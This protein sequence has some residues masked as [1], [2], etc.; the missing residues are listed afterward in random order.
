MRFAL[1][2]YTV[3]QQL[4]GD[5][6]G[7]LQRI[8][9]FGFRAVE[10]YPFPA[11]IPNALAAD[12]LRDIGL[13][14]VAIHADL[15][16][17]AG[18]GPAIEAASSL[19][20]NRIIWHGW[21]RP[22]EYNSTAGIHRLAERYTRAFVQA[23]EHGLRLGLHNHWWEFE[24]V[25]GELPFRILNR[26]MSQGIFWELDTYWIRTAG[27]DPSSVITEVGERV[28][29]LH[30]K[31]GPCIQGQ[32]MTALGDGVLDFPKIFR[33]TSPNVDLVVELDEC[34]TDIFDAVNRS[35]QF[36]SRIGRE[37]PRV[38]TTDLSSR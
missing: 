7:T 3:R 30:L 31:D 21:P 35:A 13:E 6:R 16:C 36:L 24:V 32:P 26:T 2:L 29:L 10:V 11:H 20:C 4:A 12:V 25:E 19:G 1:Q 38:E 33:R 5:F 9:E 22:P 34:A 27:F 17:D 8:R 28:E 18:L 37:Q 23:R 15:P 14:V